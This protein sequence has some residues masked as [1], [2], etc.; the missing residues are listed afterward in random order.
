MR[1]K[2]SFTWYATQRKAR[3]AGNYVTATKKNRS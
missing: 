3:R 1:M 2:C